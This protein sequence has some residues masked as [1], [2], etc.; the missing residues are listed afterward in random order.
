MD[1]NLLITLQNYGLS[2]KE[3]RVYLTVLELGA[4]PASTIA[5]NTGIKRVTIYSILKD[6]VEK[7]IVTEENKNEA[8]YFSVIHPELLLNRIQ[9][10]Y[11]MLKEYITELTTLAQKNITKEK[12][13]IDS[14]IE[15]TNT[16]YLKEKYTKVYE[17]FR[18]T[19][20]IIIS[21]NH[22]LTWWW[23]IHISSNFN[24]K[25]KIPT[26]SYV[27]IKY[28]STWDVVFKKNIEF[29]GTTFDKKNG[30]ANYNLDKL[31]VLI[32]NYLKLHKQKI[33]LDISFLMETPPAHGLG[34]LS[35]VI[36]DLAI[37]LQIITK[38]LSPDY[39]KNY[40]A[41]LK[42]A[43]FQSVLDLSVEL[44]SPLLTSTLYTY[45]ANPYAILIN[46]AAPLVFTTP[47]KKDL[48]WSQILPLPVWEKSEFVNW[49][50]FDYGVFYLG[51]G[52]DALMIIND[53]LNFKE[54]MEKTQEQMQGILS[55]L[56]Y[57]KWKLDKIFPFL[58]AEWFYEWFMNLFSLLKVQILLALY[59]NYQNPFEDEYMNK[60][61]QI[62][63]SY[64][65]FSLLV[66]WE[67]TL[68]KK[69][70]ELF[71]RNKFYDD[72]V[73]GI[74]PLASGKS[75]WSFVFVTKYKKS[76]NTIL[77]IFEELKKKYS[78]NIQLTYAS[79]IDGVCADGVL[80]EKYIPVVKK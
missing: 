34:W 7:E 37:A 56:W 4:V 54:L 66:E 42:S 20:D 23:S 61:I 6:L 12:Q 1:A 64:H 8:K 57:T 36:T 47:K 9:E 18:K 43:S 16:T 29:N 49:N 31:T 75:W 13:V 33:W 51:V 5:R 32:K 44:M 58:M 15:P 3:A 21:W 11:N 35:V 22:I 62:M 41:F 39:W 14:S 74:L 28:T 77:K 78:D 65:H 70:K 53:R 63:N 26:K 30:L 80:I 72:E 60:L 69:I 48:K 17:E 50:P 45:G 68:I 27:G 59:N 25:Q 71:E 2:E 55:D 38:Q 10:K 52:Y 46:S 40:G 73:L 76:R 19:N 24:I 79:R 67:N